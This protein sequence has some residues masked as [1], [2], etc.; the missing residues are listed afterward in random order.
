MNT[1]S[2]P[3]RI[4][5]LSEA[6][7]TRLVDRIL[8]RNYLHG[9]R[10]ITKMQEV[11]ASLEVATRVETDALKD[12]LNGLRESVKELS[13]RLEALGRFSAEGSKDR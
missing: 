6:K 5:Q 4:L 8:S 9:D 3:E 11:L 12:Q 13:T 2:W 10:G 1:R 7:I